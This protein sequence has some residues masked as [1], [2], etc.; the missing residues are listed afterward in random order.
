[1]AAASASLGIMS[2]VVAALAYLLRRRE[3][4]LMSGKTGT[5]ASAAAGAFNAGSDAAR[6]QRRRLSKDERP[7]AA[8]RPACSPCSEP[9]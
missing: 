3:P 6:E 1:M 8:A 5:S 4:E 9:K 2:N 7:F